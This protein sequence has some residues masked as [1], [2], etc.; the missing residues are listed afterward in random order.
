MVRNPP[1]RSTKVRRTRQ[2]CVN[3]SKGLIWPKNVQIFS[4]EFSGES[5]LALLSTWGANAWSVSR[6][7]G[8]IKRVGCG[9][10]NR[11]W[12]Y[13]CVVSYSFIHIFLWETHKELYDQRLCQIKINAPFMEKFGK[14]INTFYSWSVLLLPLHTFVHDKI[15]CENHEYESRKTW[16]NWF[17]PELYKDCRKH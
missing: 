14:W 1:D 4:V 6:G 3:V 17:F 10:I 9:W 15:F 8:W 5:N 13:S 16:S 2:P 12:L 7:N 11:C